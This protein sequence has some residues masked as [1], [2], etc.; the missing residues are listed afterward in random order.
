MIDWTSFILGAIIALMLPFGFVPLL[1]HFKQ[2][3]K[4]LKAS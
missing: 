3:L 4:E 2:S 1:K